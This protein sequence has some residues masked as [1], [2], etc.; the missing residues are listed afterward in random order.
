MQKK[1]VLLVNLGTP[2][3]TKISDLRAFL[4]EFLLDKR[5]IDIPYL[6][7]QILVRG[8]ILPFRPYKIASAYKSIWSEQGSPLMATSLK[9]KEQLQQSVGQEFDIQLA[10][11]YGE[12]PIR[13]ALQYFYDNKMTDVTVI[14]LFPQYST[15]ATGSVIAECYDQANRFFSPLN[16]TFVKSF[17]DDPL[18][19]KCQAQLIEK[20][21]NENNSD[22]LITSYHGVPV[23]H[24]TKSGCDKAQ[25]CQKATCPSLIQENADC[26]RAQ[27]YT[28]TESLKEYLQLNIPVH[29]TFQSRLGRTPWIKPYLDKEIER[30]AENKNLRNITVAC[31]S[32]TADCLETLE[33][34][35]EETAELWH[36]LTKGS[37]NLAPCVNSEPTFVQCLKNM[38]LE[39][40]LSQVS[41]SRPSESVFEPA[42]SI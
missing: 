39:P 32:F 30:L 1:A 25:D 18:F 21:I 3:S 13:K 33:E 22:M 26:Y 40:P 15:A 2:K 11:R 9:L 19:I 8:I 31:P 10:M 16:L 12:L 38:L 14:P 29:V 23:R 6:A 17:Y 42:S 27:C 28:T 34:V 20:A 5:V 24:L 36:K 37:L 35:A 4:R 7:R 41:K